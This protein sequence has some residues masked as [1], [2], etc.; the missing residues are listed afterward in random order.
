MRACV[1]VCVCVCVHSCVWVG[2]GGWV[3]WGNYLEFQFTQSKLSQSAILLIV[4]SCAKSFLLPFLV[5]VTL[6]DRTS[7]M[8]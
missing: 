1:C 3:V 7:S 5:F 6:H 4:M 2:L 8:T